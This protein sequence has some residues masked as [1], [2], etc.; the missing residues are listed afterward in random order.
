VRSREANWA[1]IVTA[2]I[3]VSGI[4]VA[5]A[6]ETLWVPTRSAAVD[7]SGL[8]TMDALKRVSATTGA[9]ST[10]FRPSAGFDVHGIAT[11][12]AAVWL[13]DDTRGRLYRVP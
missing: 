6:G 1:R 8:P 12:G 4:D 11:R 2:D 9:V 10:A 3:G 5:A 13:A 7:A